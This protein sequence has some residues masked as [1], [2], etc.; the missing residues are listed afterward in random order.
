MGINRHS[1]R[2]VIYGPKSFGGLEMMDLRIKHAVIQWE[3][4]R[5]HLHRLDRAGKGVSITAN[6]TQVE[7]GSSV[8]FC[9]SKDFFPRYIGS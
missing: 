7:A 6:D 8:H 5:E 9:C 4:M 3:T 1:P 2:A